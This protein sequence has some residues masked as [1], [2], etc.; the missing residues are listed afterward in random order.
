MGWADEPILPGDSGVYFDKEP[1]EFEEFK[2]NLGERDKHEA[3]AYT[4][5]LLLFF[6]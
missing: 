5:T 4:I 3:T 6:C 2:A 1:V